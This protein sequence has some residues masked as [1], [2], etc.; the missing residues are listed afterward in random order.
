MA[1]FAIDVSYSQVCVFL[2]GQPNPFNNWT[3]QHVAQGFAWR[4]G[5]VSFRTLDDGALAVS[6]TRTR[7]F[8]ES[9]TATR[10]IRVPFEVPVGKR[11][12]IGSMFDSQQIELPTGDYALIFEHGYDSEGKMWCNLLFEPVVQAVQASV[13]RADKE[14]RLSEQ[15]LMEAEPA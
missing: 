2:A 7:R 10:V 12:E 14:L 1:S 8:D 11:V 6:V 4:P 15:L 3:E 5:S 13:L 9:S